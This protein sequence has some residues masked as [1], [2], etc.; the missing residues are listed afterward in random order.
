MSNRYHQLIITSLIVVLTSLYSNAQDTIKDPL[1]KFDMFF[2]NSFAL[3]ATR[4]NTSNT[5][6]ATSNGDFAFKKGDYRSSF[7]FNV[8]FGWLLNNKNS[9]DIST[10]K[11]G[12]NFTT[13]SADLINIDGGNLRL[14][15]SY[16]MI[17]VQFSSSNKIQYS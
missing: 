3:N 2:E 6:F 4:V 13:R 12:I 11:T 10:I 5:E 9:F 1:R 16:L 14:S 17:P 15:S 7:D 8:N